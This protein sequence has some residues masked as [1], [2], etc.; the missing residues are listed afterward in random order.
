MTPT[1]PGP[2]IGLVDSGG[3][4]LA[5][6]VVGESRHV[7]EE[8]PVVQ[9]GGPEHLGNGEVLLGVRDVGENIVRSG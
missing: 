4:H 2:G 9:E 6:G 1:M 7:A 5:D 3:H 8:L